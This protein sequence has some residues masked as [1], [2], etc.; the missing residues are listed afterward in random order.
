MPERI[1]RPEI[2]SR[3]QCNKNV[4][5]YSGFFFYQLVIPMTYRFVFK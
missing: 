4:N 1:S 5:R 2:I 3:K